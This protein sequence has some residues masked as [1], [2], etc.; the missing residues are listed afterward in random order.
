MNILYDDALNVVLSKIY[1]DD[2]N[3]CLISNY[4]L[5]NCKQVCKRWKQ[6][7]ETQHTN[8]CDLDYS[9]KI[10]KTHDKDVIEKIKE[11]RGSLHNLFHTGTG[12]FHTTDNTTDETL[13]QLKK[14]CLRNK[15]KIKI[16]DKCCSGNGRRIGIN[17]FDRK[18]F[19]KFITNVVRL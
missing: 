18:R 8:G 11:R 19:E 16:G 6:L 9:I 10:C 15:I 1:N 3:A 17:Y 14:I 2:K 7:I 13:G 4:S 12:Y 5:T